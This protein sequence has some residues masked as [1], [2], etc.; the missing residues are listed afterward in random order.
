MAKKSIDEANHNNGKLPG[1][2]FG[3]EIRRKSKNT[4]TYHCEDL[5]IESEDGDQKELVSHTGSCR[6]TY[7]HARQDNRRARS[8]T[9]STNGEDKTEN[10][11]CN[12]GSV[13][14]PMRNDLQRRVIATRRV[15]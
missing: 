11:N 10:D 12:C 3:T 1:M 4:K 9:T 6:I 2:S 8:K 15:P 7:L 5:Q 14:H 13:D